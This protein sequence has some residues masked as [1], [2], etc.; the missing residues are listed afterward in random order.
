MN[1]QAGPGEV[2][3]L[4]ESA[5]AGERAAVD[6]L[7]PMVY[8]ELKRIAKSQLDRHYDPP[9]LQATSLV[10]EAY[11]KL[12]GGAPLQ[13]EN[14]AHMLSIAARAM[15]QVLVDQARRRGAQKRGGAW[16]Q[17]TLLDEHHAI[18]LKMDDV[19]TLNEAIERLEPRQRQ[20]VESRFFAGMEERE[21]A[22]ALGV[23]ERT[24]R[25]EWIKAR[26]WLVSALAMPAAGQ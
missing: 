8:D 6:Q 26:A 23:S 12:A 22:L 15:R 2:T 5:R 4:L 11:L 18:A 13:A 16:R 24:V 21:I 14:R 3:R 1:E 20:I 17:A 19:L 7:M 9:T 10:H 25:R